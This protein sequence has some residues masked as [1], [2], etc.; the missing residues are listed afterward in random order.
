MHLIAGRQSATSGWADFVAQPFGVVGA[1]CIMLAVTAFN[2]QWLRTR[3]GSRS[4]TAT[5]RLLNGLNLVGGICLFV[6]AVRRDEIVWKVLELYFIAIAAKGVVQSLRRGGR[7]LD[8][9][10]AAADAVGVR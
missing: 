4:E 7:P 2:S 1:A 3:I 9:A 6:N 5:A 8:T 10:P